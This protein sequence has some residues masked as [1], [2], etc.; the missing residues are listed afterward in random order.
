VPSGSG[1]NLV[2]LNF[3]NGQATLYF[4][5]ADATTAATDTLGVALPGSTVSSAPIDA[6]V[7]VTRIMVSDQGATPATVTTTQSG[8]T[9]LTAG[10]WDTI[11]FTVRAS[12]GNVIPD[13]PVAF[14]TIPNSNGTDTLNGPAATL[15]TLTGTTNQSGQVTVEFR[16]TQ[17]GNT[18]EI[19]AVATLGNQ[20]VVSGATGVITVV[21]GAPTHFTSTLPS[22]SSTSVMATNSTSVTFTAWDQ[23]GNPVSDT[24][25]SFEMLG[26]NGSVM[27]GSSTYAGLTNS[28]GQITVTYTP[29]PITT[30]GSG[31]LEVESVANPEAIGYSGYIDFTAPS[32][33]P[34]ADVNMEAAPVNGAANVSPGSA[35]ASALVIDG[36]TQDVL[37]VNYASDVSDFATVSAGGAM[38]MTPQITPAAEYNSSYGSA[39]AGDILAVWVHPNAEYYYLDLTQELGTH[40]SSGTADVG[41]GFTDGTSI[42]SVGPNGQL[43]TDNSQYLYIPVAQES[44]GMWTLAPQETVNQWIMVNGTVYQFNV[45]Q[46]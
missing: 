43:L 30:T 9:N 38:I 1:S 15:N 8:A 25:V 5:P 29:T 31:Q 34:T 11:T 19:Q 46:P 37:G 17:A 32:A 42:W 27:D 20:S 22:G 16:D 2:T 33:L 35:Y 23:Y 3:V 13:V 12:D 4:S 39:K 26:L 40:I 21:A 7:S 10:Q 28:S 44:A 14:H 6:D 36:T 45:Q 41:F 24:L 18:G